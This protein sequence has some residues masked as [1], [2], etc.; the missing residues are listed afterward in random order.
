MKLSSPIM[1]YL[2]YAYGNIGLSTPLEE[3]ATWFD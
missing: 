3:D 2:T 1:N